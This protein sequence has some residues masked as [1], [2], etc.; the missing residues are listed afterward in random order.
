MQQQVHNQAQSVP[1]QLQ[2]NE[3]QASQLVLSHS[4]QNYRTTAG[5]LSSLWTKNP[6]P[7]CGGLNT[8]MQNMSGV[9]QNMVGSQTGQGMPP[10]MLAN[11][12]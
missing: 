2:G 11:Q 9:S 7:S 4:I 1:I 3:T 6:V 12:Q 8:S 10:N 5:A